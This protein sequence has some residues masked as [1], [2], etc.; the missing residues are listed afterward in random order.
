[1]YA[2]GRRTC[3][4]IV[5]SASSASSTAVRPYAT[6]APLSL[7]SVASIDTRVPGARSIPENAAPIFI[8]A[9]RDRFVDSHTSFDGPCSTRSSDV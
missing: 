1:M 2:I 6:A 3:S 8:V 4:S 7:R 9:S 5:P